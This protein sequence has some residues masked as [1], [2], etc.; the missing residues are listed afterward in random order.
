MKKCVLSPPSFPCLGMSSGDVF[1]NSE[2]PSFLEYIGYHNLYN[3]I[4]LRR[5][6][7]HSGIPY[8][9]ILQITDFLVAPNI[10]ITVCSINYHLQFG[11]SVALDVQTRNRCS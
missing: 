1:T 4:S 9:G 2:A 5:R 7:S 10:N 11:Y 6:L 3:Y 8:S